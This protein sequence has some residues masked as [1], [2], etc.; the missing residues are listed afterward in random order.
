MALVP[1]IYSIFRHEMEAL[2]E[3]KHST[4]VHPKKPRALKVNKAPEGEPG[5]AMSYL[6]QPGTSKCTETFVANLPSDGSGLEK[7]GVAPILE[8]APVL[9]TSADPKYAG[10]GIKEKTVPTWFK[11]ASESSSK[12][13]G[14]DGKDGKEGADKAAGAK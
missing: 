6:Y 9:M 13:K 12:S 1:L 2:L 4:Y 7:L 3:G 5:M 8:N 11:Y 14:K 10:A